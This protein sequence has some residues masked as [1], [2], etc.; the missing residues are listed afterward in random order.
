MQINVERL[1]NT[2]DVINGISVTSEGGIDRVALSDADKKARD[3]FKQ[4]MMEEG[5]SVRIDDLGNMYGRRPGFDDNSPPICLGSHLDTQPNGGKFDGTL[6]VISALE[7]IR[8]LNDHNI[9]TRYPIEIINWTNEEGARFQP[10]LMGSGVIAGIFDQQQIYETKDAAGRKF[11]DELKRIDYL[12]QASNRLTDAKAYLELH[13]EQGPVLEQAGYGVG[14]VTGVSG[15]CWLKV[16]IKGTANHAGTCPMSMREDALVCAAKGIVEMREKIKSLDDSA[17]ITIGEINALPGVLNIIPEEA[18]F[19][20]DLRCPDEKVLLSSEKMVFE[21]LEKA[22]GEERTTYNVEK[23][24][25]SSPLSFAEDIIMEL[26][27]ASEALGI[28]ALKLVS[29]ANHDA[30]SMAKITPSGMVFVKSIGGRSHCP[31]E[32]SEWKDIE[33]AANLLLKTIISLS[34]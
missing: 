33:A 23:I 26:E 17:L 34:Q 3:M 21:I 18:V 15:S 10:A 11:I 31:E 4:W 30:K 7:I 8:A 14:I 22:C 5:L 13:I 20:V 19:T 1:K 16:T 6:G 27:K 12:G 32:L 24:W 9:Q 25:Y 2:M 29:G 28:P